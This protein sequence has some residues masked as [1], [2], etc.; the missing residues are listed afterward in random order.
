[1]NCNASLKWV[2]YWVSGTMLPITEVTEEATGNEIKWWLRLTE[3]LVHARYS[4]HILTH[5]SL[6]A[7][8]E[9]LPL[10][11]FL[12]DGLGNGAQREEVTSQD[13]TANEWQHQ[14]TTVGSLTPGLELLMSMLY[15][16]SEG[17]TW[18]KSHT[19]P[20]YAFE[21]LP[22]LQPKARKY[23]NNSLLIRNCLI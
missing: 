7:T 21:S 9:H 22:C 8:Q 6:T 16:L 14:H 11:M 2:Q 12:F 15:C 18:N 4:F 3:C 1:M 23:L 5:T 20:C 17:K 10:V 13:C 19:L